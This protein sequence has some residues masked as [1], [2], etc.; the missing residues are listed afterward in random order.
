MKDDASTRRDFLR[1]VGAA[2]ALYAGTGVVSADHTADP[3]GDADDEYW[4]AKPSGV[5][6]SYDEALLSEYQP[7]LRVSHLNE[8]PVGMYAWVVDS[9][10]RDTQALVYWTYYALQT[11]LSSADSHVQDREPIYVFRDTDTGQ[12]EEVVYSGY[13]W[14]AARTPTPQTSGNHPMMY[15]V[16]PWHHY[17]GASDSGRQIDLQPLHDVFGSWLVNG[18]AEHLAPGTV[19]NPWGM[20]SRE[21]WW[22]RSSFDFSFAET[23]AQV[24][25][26]LGRKGADTTDL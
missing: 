13:H 15:V 5:T 4:N 9:T 10:D 19:T 20:R 16:K 23:F 22:R 6:I 17:V 18:W 25:L 3:D 12:I 21:S 1:G 24:N 7:Y 26:L 14:L 2:T 8:Q 11:G